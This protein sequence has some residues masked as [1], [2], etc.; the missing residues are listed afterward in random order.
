MVVGF[1][2]YVVGFGVKNVGERAKVL[3]ST[4]IH[5]SSV[6]DTR[7]PALIGIYLEVNTSVTTCLTGYDL[8]NDYRSGSNATKH[9]FDDAIVL[10]YNTL[11]LV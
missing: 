5:P 7:L 8:T 1:R 10:L 6:R 11:H 2:V 9:K 4:L 3:P